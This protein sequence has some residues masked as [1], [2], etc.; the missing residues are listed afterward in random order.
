MSKLGC[1]C[2]N[3]ISDTT[4]NIPYKG[5]IIRDQ[6][7]ERVF[8]DGIANDINEFIEAISQGKREEWMREYFLSGYPFSEVNNL[9]V[10]SDI[11][12]LHFIKRELDIYQCMSCGSIKIQ[13]GSSSNMFSS[14]AAKKWLEGSESILKSEGEETQS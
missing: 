5:V 12:S 7:V 6:D 1:E 10:I 9:G 2:G 8:Y 13:N 4:D 11:I 3:V 14:F